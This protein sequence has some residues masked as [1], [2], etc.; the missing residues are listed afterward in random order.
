[1]TR[2]KCAAG[3]AEM[4]CRK[5]KNAA[6][7][8]LQASFDHCVCPDLVSPYTVAIYGGLCALGTFERQELHSKVLSSSSFKQFLELEPLLRDAIIYFHQSKYASCL[9]LLNELHDTF[10]LDMY[11]ANHVSMLYTQI[12]NK[13]L[14][15]YFSPYSSVDLHKMAEAFNTDVNSLENELIALILDGLIS[16]R[17]DSHAKIMYARQID[18]RG[19]VFKK[20]IE[21]GDAYVLRTKVTSF[22]TSYGRITSI[23]LGCIDEGSV[24]QQQHIC[25]ACV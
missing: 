17:I 11:L 8:F 3:L 18:Q 22:D 15:Q 10:M 21:I 24:T 13:A 9:T 20:A 23:K 14:I 7:Y 5:Y 2:L 19:A 25:N 6:R 16:A 12:R 4:E 1:V